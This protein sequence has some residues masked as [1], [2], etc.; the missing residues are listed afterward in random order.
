MSCFGKIDT[1]CI[2]IHCSNYNVKKELDQTKSQLQQCIQY[3]QDV[4]HQLI[5]MQHQV[6][7]LETNEPQYKER[8]KSLVKERDE[9]LRRYL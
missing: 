3:N 1:F 9:L 8:I 4:N 7:Y 5:D 6:R 2:I